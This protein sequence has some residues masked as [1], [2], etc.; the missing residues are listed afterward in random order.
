MHDPQLWRLLGHN[1]CFNQLPIA[2]ALSLQADEDNTRG[3][4]LTHE[5]TVIAREL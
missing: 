1:N 5:R 2:M 3:L 4:S